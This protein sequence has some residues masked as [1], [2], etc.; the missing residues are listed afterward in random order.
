M[1]EVTRASVSGFRKTIDD[2]STEEAA[3]A[4]IM[5]ITEMVTEAKTTNTKATVMGILI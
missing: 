3:L 4:K 1:E 5:G 2:H